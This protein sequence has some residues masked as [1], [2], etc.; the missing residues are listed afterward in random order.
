MKEHQ[1]MNPK[2][3]VVLALASA[4]SGCAV[5]PAYRNTPLDP[6]HHA[7]TDY[8]VPRASVR[9]RFDRVTQKN[10]LV[11]VTIS[12]GGSR[13]AN[14]AAAVLEQLDEL[15]ILPNV[16]A[17]SSVSGGSLT[18]A[19]FALTG[20]DRDAIGRATYWKQSREK[21]SRDFRSKWVV[22][23]LMP[24][25][26]LGTL[27]TDQDRT[28]LMAEVF[29]EE[30][31]G[32]A[33]FSSLGTDGPGL[34]LNATVLQEPW[35]NPVGFC[36]NRANL[37]PSVRWESVSFTTTYFDICLGSRL[38]KYPIASAVAASAAFPGVFNSSTLAIFERQKDPAGGDRYAATNY[39]HLI[40][41]GPSDNLGVE[42]LLGRLASEAATSSYPPQTECLAIVIDAFVR[43]DADDRNTRTD[44]R[45]LIGRTVDPNFLDAIDALLSRRRFDTLQRM[46]LSPSV[47]GDRA[48][49]MRLNDYPISGRSKSLWSRSRFAPTVK[50]SEMLGVQA[51]DV[52]R[53][54][55][56]G[57]VEVDK[58]LTCAVWHISLD[59][60]NSLLFGKTV[61]AGELVR[62]VPSPDDPKA[63]Y[64]DHVIARQ[65]WQEM[66][67]VQHRLRLWELTS[68]IRTDFDLVGPSGCSSRQLSD[69]L[70]EAG[71]IAVT[72]DVE[73]RQQVCAWM[74]AHR[75]GVASTCA[76]LPNVEVETA[77]P[78]RFASHSK[79][80]S[81]YDVSCSTP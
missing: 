23:N 30:L 52:T 27:F 64:V 72:H 34:L 59:D 5:A 45:G 74:V 80:S 44:T 25:K 3:I 12:G 50:V 75:L 81:G 41:G 32:G 56:D 24:Y 68:R 26:L 40:D 47:L 57:R 13:A 71:R 9:Q 53:L 2:L 78:V 6:N 48:H 46:G 22:K 62:V 63:N 17:I 4:L 42:G 7:V 31:F 69:A 1:R 43:G 51:D 66:P 38:D 54:Y 29:D 37:S 61:R 76:A 55:S 14:F 33:S 77:L 67:E 39:V 60:I 73:A 28:D 16:T 35:I 18:A 79:F 49:W 58:Q 20:K 21:L 36:T 19:H 15:G 11:G 10:L 8:D 70:W 65:T